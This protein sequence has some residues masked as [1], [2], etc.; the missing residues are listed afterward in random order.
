MKKV[1]SL[2]MMLCMLVSVMLPVSAEETVMPESVHFAFEDEAD[3]LAVGEW[4]VAIT[5]S[6]DGVHGSNG[7]ASVTTETAVAGVQWYQYLEPGSL[8]NASVWLKPVSGEIK[9]V[10]LYAITPAVKEDGS[11]GSGWEQIALKAGETASDGYVRYYVDNYRISDRVYPGSNQAPIKKQEGASSR[12]TIRV[13]QSDI[14]YLEDEIRF[15]K[16]DEFVAYEDFEENAIN[17]KAVY[18]NPTAET[19]GTSETYTAELIAHPQSAYQPDKGNVKVS[20]SGMR[21]V[22]FPNVNLMPGTTYRISADITAHASYPIVVKPYLYMK[23]SQQSS[24]VPGGHMYGPDVEIAGGET[25]HVEYMFR[26]KSYPGKFY[27]DEGVPFEKVGFVTGG[28]YVIWYADNLKIEKVQE[29]IYG[30]DMENLTVNT[31]GSK[32][33]KDAYSGN[34][35]VD[36]VARGGDDTVLEPVAD[37]GTNG[38]DGDYLKLH[39]TGVDNPD[40]VSTNNNRRGVWYLNLKKNTAHRISFKA[41]LVTDDSEQTETVA[42]MYNIGKVDANGLTTGEEGYDAATARYGYINSIHNTVKLT[43]KWQTV[44]AEFTTQNLQV[45]GEVLLGVTNFQPKADVSI[46]IDELVVEEIE[47]NF[48]DVSFENQNGELITKASYGTGVDEKSVLYTLYI[49]EDGENFAKAAQSQ[50]GKFTVSPSYSGK[51]LKVEITGKTKE[52]N[53]ICAETEVIRA[54]GFALFLKGEEKTISANASYFSENGE[55]QNFTLVVA[56]YGENNKMLKVE[57]AP[58]ENGVASFS[59]DKEEGVL[60]AKAF[61]WD[62]TTLMPKTETRELDFKLVNTI[63]CWG[64]SLT[65]GRNQGTSYSYPVGLANL[66]GLTVYNMGVGGETSTTIAA[67]QGALD[68]VISEDFVIPADKTPVEIKFEASNGGV[69]TPRN[70]NAGGWNPCV[71][72]GVEG[73]LSVEVNNTVW[74]RVLNWAKFTRKTAGEEVAV[75]AG[76]KLVPYAH[77]V[78][79]DVNIF[80][81]GTNGGWTAANT[82]ANDNSDA[83]VYALIDLIETQIAHSGSKKFVVIGLTSGGATAWDNTNAKLKDAFGENFLDVKPYLASEQALADAGITPT[84]TDLAYIA[85]GQIPKSLYCDDTDE[86]HLSDVGYSLLAQK[87]YDKLIALDYLK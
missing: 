26:T 37:D 51:F 20:G 12:M 5:P 59:T 23:T 64:D 46:A 14:T 15:E 49:S 19:A 55:M 33:Y 72:N 78:K 28:D 50:N 63:A 25:K 61:V 69:V 21:G 10:Y 82:T 13:P 6:D 77:S 68:I 86:T 87:V 57:S 11:A 71:I 7:A 36:V 52:G 62:M 4:D 58:S 47:N 16:N 29:G 40:A 44:T 3:F 75:S 56:Q 66:T 22:Y 79:G 74:P 34:E 38:D 2:L 81:T 48:Y 73:T 60:L 54:E 9:S 31:D 41:K 39:F 8:Y 76:D 67:R 30:G 65:Y 43:N 83:D 17:I 42:A 84:D 53:G 1:L 35:M 24:F 27:C 45:I 18:T 80:F 85:K 70:V 32:V